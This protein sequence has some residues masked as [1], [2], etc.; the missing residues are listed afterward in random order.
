MGVMTLAILGVSGTEDHRAINALKSLLNVL[1]NVVGIAIYI[2]YGIVA[3]PETLVSEVDPC[4]PGDTFDDCADG[5]RHRIDVALEMV[6]S[7]VDE[8]GVAFIEQV[9]V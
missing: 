2:A 9:L 3:W 4:D 7:S 5:A 8:L 1:A 6:E